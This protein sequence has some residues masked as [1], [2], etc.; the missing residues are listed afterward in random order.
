MGFSGDVALRPRETAD[1]S[2]GGGGVSKPA[3]GLDWANLAFQPYFSMTA[4]NVGFSMW[5]H[6][7]VGPS[8]D[9]E[10]RRALFGSRIPSRWW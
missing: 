9:L 10:A 5:S 7:L 8:D 4:A 2:G 1:E 3:G 6:D